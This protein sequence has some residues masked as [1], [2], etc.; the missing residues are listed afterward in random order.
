MSFS[1]FHKNYNQ[2][3]WQIFEFWFA[4]KRQDSVLK[5]FNFI[6]CS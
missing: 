1:I 5:V 6:L 4:I 3:N 2:K